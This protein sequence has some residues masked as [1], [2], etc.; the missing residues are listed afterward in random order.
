MVAQDVPNEK[1]HFEVPLLKR[2]DLRLP[3]I[4]LDRNSRASLYDQIS[5]QIARA[6]RSGEVNGGDR[7][8]STRMMAKLLCVSRN[9]VLTAY[10][11]LRA[12]GLIVGESGAGMRVESG[13]PPIGMYVV[14]LRPVIR[15]AYFPANIHLFTD[16][17]GNPLYLNF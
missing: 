2:N 16:P 8:P 10:E 7:L 15:A 11:E 5:Q 4:V 9:T 12:A 14:G 3:P 13:L 17:D 6:I 1:N